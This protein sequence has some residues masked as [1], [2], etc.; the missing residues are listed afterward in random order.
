MRVVTN[1]ATIQRNR[2][3]SQMSFLF[4]LV[5]LLASF[6]FGNTLAG[7]SETTAIYFNCGVLPTL[8][9]LILFA[10]RMANNWVRE[11]LPW[12]ALQEAVRGLSS[13]A[14][15]YHFIFP[16]RHVLIAPMGIFVLYPLF[17]D[18]RII[19]RG[20]KWRMPT[21]FLGQI[22]VFMRQEAIGNPSRDAKAEAYFMKQI[23]TKKFP[24]AEIEV[25][26]VI[27]FISPRAQ[28]TI[29]EDP[30]VPVTFAT[31]GDSPELKDYLKS[32]KNE[33][34]PTLTKDQ[35]QELDDSFIYNVN[36]EALAAEEAAR[37]DEPD[38]DFDDDD[39]VDD[40]E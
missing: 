32:L 36:K 38:D 29:E 28:V 19:V 9:F 14:V 4:S 8:F 33:D 24:D 25:Q 18:R 30:S 31:S 27:V 39:E 37:G 5:A 2:R 11:P 7:Q 12:D 40:D 26:P 6:I 1:E 34:R 15:L 10:V 3:I 21:G 13:N 20:D 22:F 23:L 35:I 16:A 17:Q